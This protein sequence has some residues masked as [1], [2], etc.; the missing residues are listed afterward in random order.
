HHNASTAEKANRL[1]VLGAIVAA[2]L[3]ITPAPGTHHAFLLFPGVVA[4]IDRFKNVV[5]HYLLGGVFALICS[6]VLGAGVRWD[7]GWSMLLAFPRAYLMLILWT[8]FLF[9]L[10]LFR[11]K[12]RPILIGL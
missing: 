12:R 8:T 4:A 3:L 2:I 7:S 11:A 5:S 1:F 9:S 10:G 6:N